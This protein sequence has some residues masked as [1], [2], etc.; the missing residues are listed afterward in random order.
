MPSIKVHDGSNW[1]SAIASNKINIVI[2]WRME[3]D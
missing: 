1:S 3:T 2:L